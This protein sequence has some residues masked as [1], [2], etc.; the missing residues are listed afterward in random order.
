MGMGR[1][2]KASGQGAFRLFAAGLFIAVIA[3]AALVPGARQLSPAAAAPVEQGVEARTY[4]MPK[5][6]PYV[7]TGDVRRL[8]QVPASPKLQRNLLLPPSSRQSPTGPVVAD[9]L[10]P[11]RA[12][13]PAP[14]QNFAGL[15]HDDMVTGGQA[16][17]GWPPDIN[18]DVGLNH[19]ILAVNSAY[20]IYDKT[21]TLLAAF[22]E[23]SLWSGAGTSPCNGNSQGDPVVLYDALAD[24]W[25]LTHFA[26]AVSGGNPVAPFYQCIA[27]S[28]T[29]DPV[30]GGWNLYAIKTDTGTTGG[31]PAGTLN[32]YGKL[33]IW[34]DCLYFA[35]NGFLYPG[36][37]FNGTEFASFSRADMYAGL[38][39]TFALGFIANTSNPFTMIPSNLAAPMGAVPPPATPNYFV[40]ESQTNFAFEV[41]KFTPGANCGGGGTLS[42]ATIINQTSYTVPG[43][44]IVPQPNTTIRLD[45]LGDRLMQKVQYRKVGLTESLW[46][47][48]SFRSS[49]T[50]PTGSQWAQIDVTGGTI[51]ATAVQQQKFDPADGIYRWMGSIAADVQGNVALGYS[52]S[53]G[54]SPNFP[55]IAYSGRLA[56]DPLNTLPQTERVLIAGGGSQT[57][58]CGGNP[59]DRWGDYTAMSVDPADGCTFWYTNE[60]YN[61]QASGT[62][63]NW[64]TRIGSFKFP[65]CSSPVV[66]TP[67]ATAA[68]TPTR[69]STPASTSTPIPT[70]TPTA[71][72]TPCILG[73][74][75]CDGIVDIRDYGIWRQQFGQ[76]NCGNPADL[77]GDCIVDIRDY[78]IWRQNFGHTAGATVPAAVLAVRPPSGSAA[79]TRSSDPAPLGGESESV[80][81]VIRKAMDAV[82]IAVPREIPVK[83]TAVIQ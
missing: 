27:A 16:G 64:H 19:Y 42:T 44:N 24:R 82:G 1:D 8:P 65:S 34:T 78:G 70:R 52:T 73:D 63:G 57:N 46:V 76:T 67:T 26:F 7:F 25:V 28:R 3:V 54:T 72:P 55:S 40:S 49:S 53:N 77:N 56:G 15:S 18:G 39:L 32:D 5:V 81:A 31:P 2:R 20:A 66:G 68:T 6:T 22:T 38:T 47:T 60:Y 80:W 74:I 41:R 51:A 4:D 43:Q 11:P 75:N 30:A 71:T 33:G 29:S 45:S 37:A 83:G 69:T 12:P 14:I 9:A 79:P 62:S 59:C 50:G 61:S 13:M 10:G 17:A 58:T 36:G 35:A 48:H 21:G 23:D